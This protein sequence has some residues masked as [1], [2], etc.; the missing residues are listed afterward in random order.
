MPVADVQP[1]P[2]LERHPS[3]IRKLVEMAASET[4]R[5]EGVSVVIDIEP[6]LEANVDASQ[7]RQLLMNLLANAVDAVGA[8]GEVSVAAAARGARLEL[9]VRDTGAGLSEEAKAHLFEPLFTTKQ[10]GIGLGLA[11]CHRIVSK[12]GGEI[13]AENHEDGGAL[14]S[15]ILPESVGS[16]A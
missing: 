4:P 16:A 10:H 6:E 13:R 1:R 12:H 3:F 5:G 7:L 9:N 11:L 2:D 14:I 8:E 15:I